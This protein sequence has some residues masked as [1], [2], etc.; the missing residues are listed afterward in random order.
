MHM[1]DLS[2]ANTFFQP[3]RNCSNATYLA[4]KN[5]NELANADQQYV[6]SKVKP[7]I[8]VKHTW[9]QCRDCN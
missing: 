2:A 5:D 9:T 3:K 4:P 7:D 6:G 1:F 8:K